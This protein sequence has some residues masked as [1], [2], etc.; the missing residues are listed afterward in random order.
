[1]SDIWVP[2]NAQ[3]QLAANLP[4]AIQQKIQNGDPSMGWEGDP[5]LY[6]Q[7]GDDGLWEVWQLRPDS[8]P[9]LAMRYDH[10]LD[11]RLLIHLREID[12][13]KQSADDIVRKAVKKME[14]DK[15][16][17]NKKDAEI[18]AEGQDRVR[19]VIKKE[20]S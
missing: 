19:F 11:E 13:R 12:P 1:M 15:A 20:L 10:A 9:R 8:P 5:T 18:L 17:K 14:T 3:R 6:L 4:F 2:P 16:N 7:L